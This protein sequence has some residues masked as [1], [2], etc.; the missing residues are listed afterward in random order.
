MD[1]NDRIS[2]ES[3]AAPHPGEVIA[4]YLE[5]F[6]WSQ[7]DL[8]RRTGLTPKTISV[9]CN[10]K[11]PVTATTALTLERAFRRPAHLWLNLQRQFDETE[12]RRQE[13]VQSVQW[14]D[15][16]RS[17]PLR[18]M[19]KFRFSLQPA[20]SE[21]DML[22]NY[23]GVSSPESWDTVWNNCDIA[24]RQT[25]QLSKSMASI[26]AWVRET[27]I[28]ATEIETADFNEKL[29][30]S[31]IGQIRRFTAERVDEAVGPVQT[32][33][34]TAGVAVVWVPELPQSGISG[35]ARWL[36]NKKALIGLTL[37]YKTDDQMWFSFFHELGHLLLHKRMRSFVLDNAA[38]DLFDRIVDPE[39][40]RYETEAN[41]F[42]ADTLIP[43]AALSDFVSRHK[44]SNDDIYDFS[45][46]VGVSPGIVVGRLQHLSFLAAYQGN[47]LKQKLEWQIPDTD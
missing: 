27:E 32:L 29:L 39:M 24:Y 16:A 10:A 7:R 47:A 34:A 20:R 41:Q 22:L 28:V 45:E 43:P 42:A 19:R 17:F 9:I 30:R 37:R 15:W 18:D 33:C 13:R 14:I 8:A 12:A 4:E 36:S 23:L 1:S 11:A 2:V 35:C 3:V 31:L 40:E 6:G 38:H 5:H 26:S 46:K 21:V 25:R 44:F